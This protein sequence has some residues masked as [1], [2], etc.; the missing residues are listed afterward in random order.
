MFKSKKSN[1]SNKKL[2]IDISRDEFL[3]AT[4]IMYAV[5]GLSKTRFE[6]VLK[7]LQRIK[8][9]DYYV[10]DLESVFEQKKNQN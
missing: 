1:D 2:Y 7:E 10:V 4:D 6:L 9:F 3:I 5:K 8:D